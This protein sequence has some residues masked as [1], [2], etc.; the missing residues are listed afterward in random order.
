M[1]FISIASLASIAL[2]SSSAFSQDVEADSHNA[3]FEKTIAIVGVDIVNPLGHDLID[4]ATVL[5][6]GDTIIRVDDQGDVEIPKG[7]D[8][9]A[10]HGKWLIPG[11]MDLHV[12]MGIDGS[13]FGWYEDGLPK[14]PDDFPTPEEN[15]E[16]AL[17]Y[18]ARAG[19]TTV[20]SCG[21]SAWAYKNSLTIKER[22]AADPRAPRFVL[23]TPAAFPRLTDPTMNY[24][25][26]S[27]EQGREFVRRFDEEYDVD[28]LKVY[29]ADGKFE[30]EGPDTEETYRGLLPIVKAMLDEGRS[31]GMRNG[32]DAV[33]VWR[34]K[35]VLRMGGNLV[36]GVFFGDVDDE[37]IDLMKRNDAHQIWTAVASV[38]WFGPLVRSAGSER[39]RGI[40]I[41]QL[42]SCFTATQTLWRT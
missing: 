25:I 5:I 19:V 4:D 14:R 41:R 2:F 42:Q 39:W 28:W 31:R 30:G 21:E 22:A 40:S 29:F 36:H 27:P 12:H 11:L 26:T 15:L 37:Y 24:R 33:E 34:A 6:R 32:V 7:A 35:D 20:Q 3:A 1:K 23:S 17:L 8:I 38:R 16:T 10:A 13:L 9:I 18:L